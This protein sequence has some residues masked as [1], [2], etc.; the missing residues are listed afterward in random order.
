MIQNPLCTGHSRL[1]MTRKIAKKPHRHAW[2]MYPPETRMIDNLP[3]MMGVKSFKVVCLDIGGEQ[4][5][6]GKYHQSKWSDKL[7]SE[8]DI[9]DVIS[10]LHVVTRPRRDLVDL[11]ELQYYSQIAIVTSDVVHVTK[12][13]AASRLGVLFHM[14]NLPLDGIKSDAQLTYDGSWESALRWYKNSRSFAR[15]LV[16]SVPAKRTPV[17]SCD[18]QYTDLVRLGHLRVT[19]STFLSDNLPEILSDEH[20]FWNPSQDY[21][22]SLGA[23][24]SCRVLTSQILDDVNLMSLRKT[25]YPSKSRLRRSIHPETSTNDLTKY[26]A[27]ARVI[28]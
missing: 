14:L 16:R 27:S 7:M 1:M 4:R 9:P 23:A 17:T 25:H 2:G 28:V 5:I 19:L 22:I 12:Q 8:C 11:P 24:G 13:L 26:R 3:P 21:Q 10:D 15:R 6:I 18:G 20:P